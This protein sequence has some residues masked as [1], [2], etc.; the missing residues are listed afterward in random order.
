MSHPYYDDEGNGVPPDANPA[1]FAAH[2]DVMRKAYYSCISYV[3]D[4]IGQLID[5][6]DTL[7]AG[8][9]TAIVF[10]GDHGW[11]TG[12][13][14]MWCK[15]SVL[16]LG[17]RV[18]LIFRA[19]W[20][21]KGDLAG[22]KSN[23]L[24]E[25]VDL[26]PTLSELAGLTL[27][28]GAGGADLGGVSLVPVMRGEV[29]QVKNA[30]LSQFP[31]CYQNNSH[32]SGG[33]PGDEGNRT[34]SWESMSDCHWTDRNALDFMGY[35]LRTANWS[36]TSWQRWNGE[37]L[38]PI[39]GSDCGQLSEG[40]AGVGCFELYDHIGDDG[41]APA[42]FDD[43]ENVNLA[44]DPAHAVKLKEMLALLKQNVEK[45]I[46]PWNGTTGGVVRGGGA[47]ELEYEMGNEDESGKW[48]L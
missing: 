37:M 35:K 39:W 25:L 20:I 44:A 2:Q 32:H 17:T 24:A 43:Y 1:N 33:K 6:L 22:R 13:H 21:L 9:D 14:D 10:T 5:T 12:E 15:M 36:I 19:P 4:L 26:Y 31:R 16:E 40:N 34:V 8:N 7:G 48:E 28:R 45:W 27:P 11:H 18:P 42:A 41:M 46:T 30:T 47:K 3:D 29:E 23:A 38:R